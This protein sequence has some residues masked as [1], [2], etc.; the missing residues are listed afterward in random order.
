E[1]GAFLP[2][3][4]FLE[5]MSAIDDATTDAILASMK[6]KGLLLEVERY[7]HSYPRCW[8]C[9]TELLF[10]LVDEWFISRSRRDEIMRVTEEVTFLPEAINGKAR[11]LDWLRNM[12][13]WMTSKKRWWALALPI[14]VDEQTGDFELIGARD[15]LKARAVE[16]WDRFDGHS[17]H[18]PWVDEVKV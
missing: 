9:K 16:G 13:D 3:F 7:P 2:G 18:R 6:E 14:W 4:G 17:P 5:G 15:D 11:E 10:R 8:R 1:Y 12:G